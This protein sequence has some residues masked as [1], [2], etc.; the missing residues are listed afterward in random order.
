MS[1]KLITG[2]TR[3]VLHKVFKSQEH[4]LNFSSSCSNVLIPFTI[5]NVRMYKCE[6]KF[7]FGKYLYKFEIDVTCTVPTNQGSLFLKYANNRT[8]APYLKRRLGYH[9]SGFQNVKN[10]CLMFTGDFMDT[11]VVI[12]KVSIIRNDTPPSL[13]NS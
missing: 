11:E 1:Y 4:K 13:S 8:L 5:S 12:K 6:D 2:K 7:R 9:W 10:K 3:K